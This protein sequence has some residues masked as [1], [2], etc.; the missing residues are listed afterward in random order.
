MCSGSCLIQ[1]QE[2]RVHIESL[3][4]GLTFRGLK[5]VSILVGSFDE[6]VA[7]TS[8]LLVAVCT[9]LPQLD[10][11]SV[12]VDSVRDDGSCCNEVCNNNNIYYSSSNTATENSSGQRQ[13]HSIPS[14]TTRPDISFSLD[15]LLLPS[16]FV[17]SPGNPALLGFMN[18]NDK[19]K[20]STPISSSSFRQYETSIQKNTLLHDPRISQAE[21]LPPKMSL[22]G[23]A[24]E[25]GGNKKLD[26]SLALLPAGIVSSNDGGQQTQNHH[27][28][29][30]AAAREAEV[31]SSEQEVV[32]PWQYIL[33][34]M[35][36]GT[37][38][39]Q[40]CAI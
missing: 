37:F 27:A 35:L 40:G 4:N 13:K 16:S 9:M 12:L 38:V 11:E 20:G 22:L 23:W 29:Q 31:S 28:V 19:K 30:P 14:T 8:K 2:D 24:S 36:S 32:P 3:V 34:E 18:K 5:H 1:S 10:E 26:R 7:A 39:Q 6:F 21:P 15:N 33:L 25:E 17:Y